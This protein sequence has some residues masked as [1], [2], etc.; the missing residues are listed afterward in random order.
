MLANS[1]PEEEDGTTRKL[2]DPEIFSFSTLLS[3][4]GTETVARFLSWAACCSRNP[5]QRKVLVDDPGVIPNAVEETLRY[6]AP[7]PVKRGGWHR[8]VEFHGQTIPA[9]RS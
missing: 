6:E 8:D 5:D 9:A 4:A 7:S 3:I 1:D 2:T